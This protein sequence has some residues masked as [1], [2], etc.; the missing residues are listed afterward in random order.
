M[1]S[2]VPLPSYD[3]ELTISQVINAGDSL[4]IFSGGYYK[5]TI[6]RVVQPPPDQRGYNRLGAFYFAFTD[7]SVR[8]TPMMESPLVQRLGVSE[9][10]K[11][12]AFVPPTSGEYR[13]ARV[14]GYGQHELKKG[15]QE[16][17][18]E[19][20]LAGVLVKHYL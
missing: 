8:L 6:H 9:R 10:F 19:E 20:V 5:P 17:T 3:C 4:E 12:D 7:D 15:E 11:G 18:E 16:G 2:Y 13:K 1:R 14:A